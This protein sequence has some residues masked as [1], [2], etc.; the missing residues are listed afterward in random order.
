MFLR[1]RITAGN[2]NENTSLAGSELQRRHRRWIHQWRRTNL[3]PQSTS[4]LVHHVQSV[5]N[6]RHNRAFNEQQEWSD[7]WVQRFFAI[8][9]YLSRRYSYLASSSSESDHSPYRLTSTKHLVDAHHGA[10]AKTKPKRIRTIFTPEQLERLEL[11]FDKQQYMVGNERFYLAT[12]LDLTEAQ[13]K[14]SDTHLCLSLDAMSPLSSRFGFKIVVSSGVG[15]PWTI[16]NS[17]WLHWWATSRVRPHLLLRQVQ[18]WEKISSIPIRTIRDMFYFIIKIASLSSFV[19]FFTSCIYVYF[20]YF[21]SHSQVLVSK[22]RRVCECSHQEN[23][24][25]SNLSSSY[26]EQWSLLFFACLI[27]FNTL[28]SA[29]LFSS[30]HVRP[31]RWKQISEEKEQSILDKN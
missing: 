6:T 5:E 13:V 18:V 21:S 25:Y 24:T 16:I 17:A 8:R 10:N 29:L 15:K 2:E 27:I 28:T 30:S 9:S 23:E 12:T 31:V 14:V 3:L 22:Q 26:Q 19:A 1:H 11:E 20:Q 7:T 4:L